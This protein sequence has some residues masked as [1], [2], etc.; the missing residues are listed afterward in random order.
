[1]T[2][3]S[4]LNLLSQIHQFFYQLQKSS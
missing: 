2:L 3:T 1:M 4:R